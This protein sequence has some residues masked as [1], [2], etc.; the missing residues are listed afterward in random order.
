MRSV[1]FAIMMLCFS[2]AAAAIAGCTRAGE[3][4]SA[5]DEALIRAEAA[6]RADELESVRDRGDFQTYLA[7][8]Q[9]AAR[10]YPHDAR[11]RVLAAE[12]LLA[13]GDMPAAEAAALEAEQLAGLTSEEV[14]SAAIRLWATARMRQGLPLETAQLAR[15]ALDD[16]ALQTV[17][18]WS[19]LLSGAAPFQIEGSAG[20]VVEAPLT[21]AATGSLA[22]ELLAID[23][24]AN[25]T[26]CQTI[27]VDTGAQHTVI[28]LAA[29]EAAG[30]RIRPGDIELAGFAT[31]T[32]QAGLIETLELGS[33]TIHNV[34]VLV[35]DS[36]A[37]T[38]AGG[39]M[40][41]GTDLLV[42]L[43]VTLDY[44]ARL[45][46]VEPAAA[47]SEAAVGT[48]SAE[49]RIPVWMFSR[50]PLAQGLSADGSPLRVLIDTGDRSGT[51]ISYR[52]GRREIPQLA[53]VHSGMVFRFKKKDLSLPMIE[54]GGRAIADWPVVDT[55]PKELDRLD[56][57]DLMLGHDLLERF[58]V[59][60]DLSRSEFRLSTSD[61]QAMQAPIRPAA[62]KGEHDLP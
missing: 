62:A 15:I 57:V 2:A 43:R 37:L 16:P 54:L 11:I 44:P 27:F 47:R 42:H 5:A 4:A 7:M 60:V 61:P 50:L 40:S 53:G 13:S 35:G 34:P 12:G 36:P 33:L 55:L 9:L 17:L 56:V 58:R 28:T 6:A 38:A 52:W 26:P 19:D 22:A 10:T 39:S 18:A 30:V 24:T 46:T 32:A 21:E 45:V 8:S 3:A 59:T 41:L 49:W 23:G 14:S 29:A 1:Y 48:A 20:D 51:Y 25:G 31:A